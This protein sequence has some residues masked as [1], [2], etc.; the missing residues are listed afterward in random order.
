MWVCSWKFSLEL[1]QIFHKIAYWL[2]ANW[3]TMKDRIGST[4]WWFYALTKS[5]S[6]WK[7]Q[8]QNENHTSGKCTRKQATVL[9]HNI[10]Q[11]VKQQ[12]FCKSILTSTCTKGELS[13]KITSSKWHQF[14]N[15]TCFSPTLLKSSKNPR[16][17]FIIAFNMFFLT[18]NNARDQEGQCQFDYVHQK[19]EQYSTHTSTKIRN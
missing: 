4:K 15:E 2:V 17:T 16:N 7:Q 8:L 6:P 13:R 5:G 18:K 12:N 19:C 10:L 14:Y 3:N 1:V 9:M 11:C